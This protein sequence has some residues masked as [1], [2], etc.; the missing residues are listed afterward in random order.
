MTTIT[1]EVAEFVEIARM[2]ELR[3]SWLDEDGR[4]CSNS[5]AGLRFRALFMA[6]DATTAA[7]A[8]EQALADELAM[9]AAV[10][11]AD[12]EAQEISLNG[13]GERDYASGTRMRIN[14]LT[15]ALT[16]HRAARQP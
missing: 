5:V 9:V 10:I 6:L 12:A 16:R 2:N 14:R 15:D 8:A 4:I 11:R 3:D 1:P 13:R 7:L